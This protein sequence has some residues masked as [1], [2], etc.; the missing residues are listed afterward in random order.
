MQLGSS[1]PQIVA[2]PAAECCRY[3]GDLIVL[4]A[5]YGSYL[6]VFG[7]TYWLFCHKNIISTFPMSTTTCIIYA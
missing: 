7:T 5:D 1:I 6:G 2:E 4:D 3:V